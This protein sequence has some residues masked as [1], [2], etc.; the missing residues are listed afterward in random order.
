M[1][2]DTTTAARILALE[3]EI[4]RLKAEVQEL[5]KQLDYDRHIVDAVSD[6]Q[7]LCG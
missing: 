6:K 2:T 7:L 5:K 3:Q 4:K 1:N